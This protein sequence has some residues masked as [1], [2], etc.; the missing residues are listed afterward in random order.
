M[1]TLVLTIYILY[2]AGIRPVNLLEAEIDLQKIKDL[3]V[4]EVRTNLLDPE[5]NTCNVTCAPLALTLVG[6]LVGL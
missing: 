6:F 3:G 5:S 4:P 1:L 2:G